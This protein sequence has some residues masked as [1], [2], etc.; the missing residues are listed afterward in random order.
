MTVDR[1]EDVR[2][3]VIEDAADL[4]KMLPPADRIVWPSEPGDVAA[5]DEALRWLKTA[6]P[7]LRRAWRLHKRELRGMRAV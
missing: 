1:R 5:V 4:L 7:E 3:A 6:V 2:Y